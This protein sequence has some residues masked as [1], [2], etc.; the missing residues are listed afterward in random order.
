M[1]KSQITDKDVVYQIAR[2]LVREISSYN[3]PEE[4]PLSEAVERIIADGSS[5]L[6]TY[7]ALTSELNQIFFSEDEKNKFTAVNID[8]F[9]GMLLKESIDFVYPIEGVL[10]KGKVRRKTD[11]DLPITAFVVN[12]KT[13]LPKK[14]I[15]SYFNLPC[16]TEPET[17]E[18][19]IKLMETLLTYNKWSEYSKRIDKVFGRKK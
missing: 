11:C 4:L 19:T 3:K 8:P 5:P 13:H 17:L 1:G 6:I 18:S 2:I 10:H 7:S 12:S 9:L 16:A 15:F 14:N